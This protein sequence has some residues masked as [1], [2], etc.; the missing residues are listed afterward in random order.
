MQSTDIRYQLMARASFTLDDDVEEW[1]ESRMAYG[2]SKSA[3]YRYAAETMMQA[4]LILNEVYERYQ[5]EERAELV[6]A[7]IKKEVERRKREVGNGG[8]D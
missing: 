5:Y 6:E 8:D 3:W 2:Q 4:E 1:V 7:A